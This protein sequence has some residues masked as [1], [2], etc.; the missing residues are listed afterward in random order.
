MTK[1]QQKQ[2]GKAMIAHAEGKQV[3][4]FDGIEWAD[5]PTPSWK[6]YSRYR[7]KPA[8]STRPW[9]KPEDVPGPVCWIKSRAETECLVVTISPEG[10]RIAS[11]LCTWYSLFDKLHSTDRKTWLP[12][13]VTEEEK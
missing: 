1:E 6:S 2:F 10:V 11:G 9:S 12:C 7:P 13:V 5:C 8:P 3:Q 4:F